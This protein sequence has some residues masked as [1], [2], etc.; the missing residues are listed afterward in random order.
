MADSPR[1]VADLYGVREISL[2]GSADLSFWRDK[3][4]T[5]R[6]VPLADDGRARLLVT[7]AA[8][9]FHGIAFR[10][11]SFCVLLDA[12]AAGPESAF[13]VHAFNS[14]R[15]FACCERLF[16]QTPYHPAQLDVRLEPAPLVQARTEQG[17]SITFGMGSG[18]NEVATG[19]RRPRHVGAASWEGRIWLPVRRSGGARRWFQAILQG[20]TETYDW[21]DDDDFQIAGTTAGDILSVLVESRFTPDQWQIRRAARHAKSKTYRHDGP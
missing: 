21:T 6:L 5:Q 17:G 15:L 7:A 9:R 16:F 13:L 19:G 20:E 11:L 18:T 10:E 8:G 14:S 1:L 12:A 4:T 2:Q 3:L